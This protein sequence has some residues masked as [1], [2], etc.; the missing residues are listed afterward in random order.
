MDFLDQM[1]EKGN[2][3]AQRYPGPSVEHE[4]RYQCHAR[5][6]FQAAKDDIKEVGCILNRYLGLIKISDVERLEIIILRFGGPSVQFPAAVSR[7]VDE[8]EG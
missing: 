4:E 6:Y 1:S 7:L 5:L 8:R 3:R 2:H